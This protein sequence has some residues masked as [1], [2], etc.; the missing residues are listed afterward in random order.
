MAS[1]TF[2][3]VVTSSGALAELMGAPS[4]LAVK[5]QLD[6]LDSHM[7]SFIGASPFLL[8]GTVG[9]SG[10]CDVSPRGDAP[11]F[12][13]ALNSRTL[14]IPERPGNRRTDSLRNVIET[15][16][17]GLLFLIPGLGETL[18]VNGRACVIQDEEILPTL[19]AQG[20][21]PQVAVAV[22]VEECF[23][24]CAKAL[25]RS[26][27]WAGREG[28]PDLPLACFSQMLMDQTKLEGTTREALEE[29]I[30]ASYNT[31]Y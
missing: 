8:L 22:D 30:Q 6:E 10:R 4:D 27:L 20:K 26:E 18:R 11:G 19:A 3:R 24:Q 23:L 15:G 2:K 21:T 1:Y 29:R 31:L 9:S 14:V 12:V 13:R 7:L 25:L 5:K 16:A 28:A 17:V